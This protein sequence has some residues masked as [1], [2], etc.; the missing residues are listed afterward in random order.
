M[1]ARGWEEGR[2]G[3]LLFNGY[4]VSVLQDKKSFED[5]LHHSVNALNTT[6][7]YT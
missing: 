7:L 2:N 5:S 1:V 6:E 3:H 4:R